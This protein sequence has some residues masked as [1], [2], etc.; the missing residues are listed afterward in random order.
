M[1]CHLFLQ[2]NYSLL[3]IYNGEVERARYQLENS[4]KK[5]AHLIK[6]GKVKVYSDDELFNLLESEGL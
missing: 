1:A 2:R 6:E 3:L 4:V 5:K